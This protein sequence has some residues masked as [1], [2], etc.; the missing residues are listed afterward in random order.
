MRRAVLCA[1]AV[2]LAACDSSAPPA[3]PERGLTVMIG[4]SITGQW[5]ALGWHTM[6]EA[7]LISTRL[8]GVIDAGVGGQTCWDMAARFAAD[9]VARHPD[10]VVIECGTNDI[11]RLQ[12]DD[13]APLFAMVE[14]AHSAGIPRVIVATLPPNTSYSTT[15]ETVGY[16]LHLAWNKAIH[17]GALEY[18]Y[19]V[20]DY[21]AV[22]VTPDGQQIAADFW[23][24][25]V[26]PINTGYAAMWAALS[27]VLR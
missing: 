27:E 7:D 21:Y 24:D 9:V 26:H 14:A 17:D 23:I 5:D 3:P 22:L 4:D 25:G 1:V 16:A 8:P 6:T 15:G 12:S 18:G 20:A 13:T 10:T 11:Y 2:A 19:T